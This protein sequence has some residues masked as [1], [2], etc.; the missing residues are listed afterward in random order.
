MH[1]NQRIKSCVC[2]RCTSIGKYGCVCVSNTSVESCMCARFTS[3][4]VSRFVCAQ[5]TSTRANGEAW[6]QKRKCN[7]VRADDER[8]LRQGEVIESVTQ[9]SSDLVR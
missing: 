6:R 7:C 9:F 4:G 2:V 5:Y 1:F 8:G 3:T